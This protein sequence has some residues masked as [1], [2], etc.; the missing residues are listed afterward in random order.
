MTEG[1]L[2]KTKERISC[3]DESCIGVIGLD[4]KCTE[5]GR[6]YEGKTASCA[7]D[8]NSSNAAYRLSDQEINSHASAEDQGE[9]RVLCSDEFCIGVIG[10][11]GKCTECGKQL[12]NS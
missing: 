5:C 3:S 12:K 8:S 4:G 2:E 9:N 6:A 10:L 7:V 11:D 1:I